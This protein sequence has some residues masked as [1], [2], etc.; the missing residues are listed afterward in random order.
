MAKIRVGLLF[1]G[2]SGEHEVS[3]NSAQAIAQALQTGNNQDKYDILP[4]YIQKNGVWIAGET[5]NR[6]LESKTPLPTEAI[7]PSQLWQFPSQVQDVAVWFPV[8]H[9]PNGEDG[10]IQGLLT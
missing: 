10:T 6:V 9:G 2:R 1:G 5:A 3:I 4:V 7:N 8:L